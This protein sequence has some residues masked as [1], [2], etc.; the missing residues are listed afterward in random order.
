MPFGYLISVVLIAVPALVAIAPRRRPRGLASLSFRLGVTINE[1]PFVALYWLAAI[2][3]LAAVQG[4]VAAPGGWL[5]LAIAIVGVGELAVLVRRA[6][7]ARPA[8]DNALHDALGTTTA[9]GLPWPTILFAPLRV[10]RPDVERTA[11]ISYGD[12]GDR[13]LLDVYRHRTHPEGGPVLVYF[14]GGGFVGGRKN[15]E[16]RALVYRLAG[17]GWICISANYRLRPANQFP[18]PLIDAKR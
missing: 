7:R 5:P 4:D 17:Q 15:R 2:T 3:A 18:D 6:L 13:N 11:D 12:A 10:R 8:I 14:H 9:P 16:A 1:L